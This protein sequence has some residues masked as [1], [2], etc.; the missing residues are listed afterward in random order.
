LPS[1]GDAE[2]LARVHLETQ[3]VEL[4]LAVELVELEHGLAD[5]DVGLL[6]SEQHRAAD[7]H[8]CELRLRRPGR[9]RLTDDLAPPEHRDAVGDLEHLVELVA[10]EHD[11]LARL[12][13][14]AEV[15]EQLLRLRRRQDGRGLV[16]DQD[17]HAPVQDLQDLDALLLAHREVLHDRPGVHDEPVLLRQLADAFVRGVH[18]E[19][20]LVLVAE[21]DGLG[22][23]E[24]IDEHEVLVDHADAEG[25]RHARRRRLH[26][27]P[28]HEDPAPVGRVH[29]VE[30]PHQRRLAGAV[31]AD[32][33]VD[34]AFA[35]LEAHVVVRDHA[36]EPLR[37]VFHHDERR[38]AGA[39]RLD[40]TH[41][42]PSAAQTLVGSSGTTIVPSMIC[43][44]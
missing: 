10:D 3:P 4:P 1:T 21:D 15:R 5:L 34:L 36:G 39:P 32:E 38:G 30:R 24:G 27:L 18:V 16:H 42:R 23:R 33:R 13:E 9:R 14:L 6:Q 29:P 25:D 22:D 2:D 12:T 31:L 28:A 43:C 8:L 26:L 44:R 19:D 40:V 41:R 17:V 20:A 7:H 37:D 11:G 35:K